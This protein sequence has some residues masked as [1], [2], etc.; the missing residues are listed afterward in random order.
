MKQG[1]IILIAGMIGLAAQAQVTPDA[2]T[3][4]AVTNVTGAIA[5]LN[6]G[7]DGAIDGFL[8]GTTTLLSFPTNV[9]GGN[10]DVG[11]CRQ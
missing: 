9:S 11:S 5:Q 7:T 10:R 6:Y 4:T 2:T 1:T 3:V 8:I